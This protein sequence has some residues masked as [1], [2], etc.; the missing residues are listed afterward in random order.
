MLRALA[1]TIVAGTLAATL[2]ACGSD[3]ITNPTAATVVASSQLQFTPQN[4]S[5]SRS[6]GTAQ[7][8]FSFESTH[9]T[10]VWDT[11]PSGA[12]VE[13][14]ALSANTSVERDMTVAGTYMYHCS[15]HPSMTGTVTIH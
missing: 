3:S 9:H 11:Q 15:I 6:G 10:V 14:I 7:L 2:F 8:T 13:N 1:R 5:L 4:I 12:S